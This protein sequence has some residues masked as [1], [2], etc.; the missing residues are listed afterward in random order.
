MT[1]IFALLL[2]LSLFAIGRD[3]RVL[4]AHGAC[5][6]LCVALTWHGGVAVAA[7]VMLLGGNMLAWWG[8]SRLAPYSAASR[9]AFS[10]VALAAV[11]G[12]LLA[13]L[14]FLAASPGLSV[15]MAG[16][17][18][19]IGLCAT[20]VPAPLAQFT[21]LFCALNG[22]IVLAG[23]LGNGMLLLAGFVSWAA[24]ATLGYW[25]LPRLTWLRADANDEI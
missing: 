4:P 22:L 3:G 6:A 23:A 17:V 7:V 15:S 21:G 12:M 9:G 2:L 24:L 10:V 25:L 8:L 18:V 1:L 11:G 16:A 14:L 13:L 5:G 19:L 20:V